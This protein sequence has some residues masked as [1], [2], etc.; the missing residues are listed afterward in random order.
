VAQGYRITESGDLRVTEQ[1]DSRV[2][3]R[4]FT[5][6]ISL[7]GSGS[8][9]PAGGRKQQVSASLAN[10]GSVL[11]AGTISRPA[12]VSATA[13]SSIAS[14]AVLIKNAEIALQGV[15][16]QQAQGDRT[17]Q[18]SIALSS[19]STNVSEA[20]RIKNASFAAQTTGSISNVVNLRLSAIFESPEDNIIRLT[21]LGDTRIT[22]DGNV[23]VASDA[24]PNSVY[25]TINA[26]GLVRPFAA[27]A[28]IKEDGI[29]KEFDPYVK[30]GGDWTLPEKVYKNV[31]NRWKR[32]Y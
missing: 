13:T 2:S 15:G 19:T 18:A 21:E 10:V 22:E 7:S 9:A 25:G 16:T 24:S 11:Y 6:S 1:S 26:D 17:A 32:V 3:E 14:S 5:G 12:S 8:L 30:W 28:Y 20:K 4:Y 27:V 23:R 29:W 31:S